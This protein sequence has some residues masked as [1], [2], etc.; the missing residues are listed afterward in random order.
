MPVSRNDVVMV[1]RELLGR[2]PENTDVICQHMSNNTDLFSLIGN[3]LRGSE[4][5][6]LFLESLINLRKSEVNGRSYEALFSNATYAP[7]RSDRKFLKIYKI[8]ASHTLV[9]L[10][11][12]W[13]LWHLVGQVAKCTARLGHFVEIGVWRGGTGVLISRAMATHG[14]NQPVYLCDTFQGVIKTGPNDP[15]YHGGEHS[16]TSVEVVRAL[17]ASVGM[18]CCSYE[19]VTGSFPDLMPVELKVGGFAFA[20]IDVD[21]YRSAKECFAAIWPRMYPGGVV[22]FDDYG[23]VTTSGVAKV[24]DELMQ[25]PDGVCTYNLTGQAVFVKLSTV[26]PCSSR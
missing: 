17:A 3:T 23:F 22:V 25:V 26:Q 12:C 1:Y 14:L 24:V 4:F 16:D 19:I 18:D 10:Y 8:I 6:Q 20:H 9:D 15:H 5:K 7:W 11:R 2:D 13:N 21:T